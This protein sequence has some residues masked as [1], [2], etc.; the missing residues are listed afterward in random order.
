MKKYRKTPARVA[1]IAYYQRE[2]NRI[3]RTVRDYT[4]KGF[5]FGNLPAFRSVR[6]MSTQAIKAAA[7]KLATAYSRWD[8]FRSATFKG[9]PAFKELHRRRKAGARKAAKTRQSKTPARRETVPRVSDIILNQIELTLSEHEQD[10]PLSV[11]M[12]REAL[13]AAIAEADSGL[14]AGQKEKGITGRDIVAARC[15]A[16]PDDVIDALQGA[17]RYDPS[18]SLGARDRFNMYTAR[19]ISII[20]RGGYNLNDLETKFSSFLARDPGEDNA[21]YYGGADP[22][23]ELI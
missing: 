6:E 2:R 15:E 12:L 5:T 9:A 4:R 22:S 20:S 10:N 19:F 13:A 7:R 17:L 3:Q 14:T 21:S 1:A 8:L 18:E 16:V 11:S 23:E